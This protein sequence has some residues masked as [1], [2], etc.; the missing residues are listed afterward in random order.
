MKPF[1]KMM[2]MKNVLQLEHALS[3][4]TRALFT[5]NHMLPWFG[6]NSGASLQNLRALSVW[7]PRR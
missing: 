2:A 3:E 4:E 7:G 1:I 6:I 5:T